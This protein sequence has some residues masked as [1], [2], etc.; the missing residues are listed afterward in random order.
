MALGGGTFTTQNKVLPGSYYNV[1]SVARASTE[2]SDRG[3]VAMP[4]VLDW[5]VEDKIFTVT[6]ADLKKNSLKL[7]GYSNTSPKLAGIRDLFLNAKTL[8]AYRLN[9]GEK[10]SNA[11]ATARYSGIRGNDIKITVAEN[12]DSTEEKKLY[13]V[14]TRLDNAVV[15]T[16]TVA[17]ASELKGNDYVEFKKDAALTPAVSLPLTGGTNGSEVTG[18]EHQEFLNKIESYLFHALGV[19]VE[20]DATKK[21]YIAFT[22]RMRDEVG[23]KFQTVLY[24][25]NKADYEGIVSLENEVE[26]DENGNAISYEEGEKVSVIGCGKTAGVYW[27]TGAIGGCNINAS[28]TNKMYNGKFEV[29]TDYS[30]IELEDNIRAGKFMLHNVNG[31]TRVLMDINTFTSFTINKNEDFSSNQTIRVLDQDAIETGNIFNSRY[32]GKVS[33]DADGR[34]ALH[35][36]FVALAEE[37]QRMRAI[38]NFSTKDIVVEAGTNKKVVVVTKLLQPVNCMEKLYTTVTVM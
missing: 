38:E 5:G 25:A 8:Y 4:F 34:I 18:T 35:S 19:P 1:I 29:K 6:A 14:V 36:D 17:A 7:F 11:V 37:M 33:N 22:K 30:Q 15:D 23:A 16:Q 3:I 2:L 13:D 32:L 26:T 24:R 28:N 21:L 12:P 10:A 9:K 20:D 27:V 31:E